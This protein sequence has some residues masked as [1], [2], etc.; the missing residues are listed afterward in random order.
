MPRIF[1]NIE[2]DLL[3]ALRAT[4]EAQ[5]VE[6]KGYFKTSANSWVNGTDVFIDWLLDAL[7]RRDGSLGTYTMGNIGG[8]LSHGALEGQL[9]G[10]V[11]TPQRS[12]RETIREQLIAC[13]NP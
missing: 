3:P 8:Y 13:E 1:D 7:F 12:S 11:Q 5:I 2:L 10:G 4:L 9:S 6:C